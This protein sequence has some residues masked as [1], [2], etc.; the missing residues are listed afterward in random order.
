MIVKS[1]NQEK[2]LFY[3]SMKYQTDNVNSIILTFNKLG[4][5]PIKKAVQVN[6]LFADLDQFI[7]DSLPSR[8]PQKL[9]GM[10]IKPAKAVELLELDTK[11]IKQMITNSERG[12]VFTF[13]EICKYDGKKFVVDKDKA[14]ERAKTF[15]TIATTPREIEVAT[16]YKKT[17][18]G[19]NALIKVGLPIDIIRHDKLA[20]W[21]DIT[22]NE[23]TA[24]LAWY[25]RL[26]R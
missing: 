25:Q 21:I 4:L 18:E 24:H 1:R 2:Q 26:I 13:L 20:N 19:I 3:E 17:I 11:G 7:I 10:S 16:A 9:F 15:D 22:E 14:T 6:A 12:Q 5:K 8:E 23:L